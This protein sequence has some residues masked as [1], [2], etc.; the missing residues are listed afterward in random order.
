MTPHSLPTMVMACISVFVGVYHLQIGTRRRNHPED[1]S[2]GVLCVVTALYEAFCTGL[3][4]ADSAAAGGGW[5]RLQFISIALFAPAFLWF[6]ADYT[7]RKKGAVIWGFMVFYLG[8]I[9]VQIFDRSTLTW[10][11]ALPSVKTIPLPFGGA[12]TYYEVTFGILTTIQSLTGLAA[13]GYII[14]CGVRFYRR[15]NRR[16][17]VPLLIALGFMT[18]AAVNDTAVSN[19][20]YPFIYLIEYGYLAMILLMTSSLSRA[21]VDSAVAREALEQAQ[22][23]IRN[24]PVVLFRW[25]TEESWPVLY[26]SE[27]VSQFGYTPRELVSGEV[28]YSAL[29]HPDDLARVAQEVKGHSAAARESFTQ[30]YRILTRGGQV[31]WIDDRTTVIRNDAGAVTGY[32]GIVVDITERTRAEAEIRRLNERLEQRVRERTAELESAVK[33]LEAFAYSVSHDLRA[34]LRAMSGFASILL[35]DFAKELP[36]EA[37]RHL[38]TI[39]GTSRQMGQLIDDLLRFSRLNRQPVVLQSCDMD[40]AAREALHGLAEERAGRA[41]EVVIG[42]LAPCRGDVGLLKQ[43]WVNLLSNALKYTRRAAAARIEIGCR[44]DAGE[45]VYFVKDNGAGFDMRYVDKLFG[46]FQRLHTDSEFEGTG[47]GLAIV[48]R[49]VSRH[50][51]RVWAHSVLGEGAEFSFTIPAV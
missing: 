15:G 35:Q 4:N 12:V 11:A 39:N 47:I 34:P 7:H 8:A 5:Q 17:A 13:T 40:A 51:G 21:V 20:L 6:V 1:I 41:V 28:P 36:E 29:V 48:K 23:V 33:E 24:S 49:I 43:V 19:G 46:V 16:E 26:V 9:L 38:A 42:A 27:N 37:S 14:F 18:L 31:R 25:G 3:Y 50:G 44:R 30:E 32:Q 10:V 2:F 22:L 45:L